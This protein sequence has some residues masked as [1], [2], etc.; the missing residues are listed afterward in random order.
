MKAIINGKIIDNKK[1]HENHALAFDEKI[2][3][4]V[5]M[6]AVQPDWTLIDACGQYVSPGF[7]DTHIHG[8]AGSDVMDASHEAL[9]TISI[10]LLKSGVTSYLPTT[11]TMAKEDIQKALSS[12]QS[13]MNN[14]S[15]T[16]AQI[17]GVHLEGPFISKNYKG[18][19]DASQIIA[20]S[21]GIIDDYLDIIKIITYAPEE[22]QDF[23]FTREM[24]KYDGI[25]LAIGHSDCTYEMALKAFELGVKRITHCFNAMQPLHH[26]NPGII[27]ASL[28]KP[29]ISEFIADGIHSNIEF[30]RSFIKTRHVN[31]CCLI[32]DSMRASFLESGDYDLGGQTVVVDETSARLKDGTLAGSILKMDQAVKNVSKAPISLAEAVYM[33]TQVP[34]HSMGLN[35][36]GSFKP[37]NDADIIF[38]DSNIHITRVFIKSKE[39][40]F[41]DH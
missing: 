38:F 11:M 22:D 20:P 18:A 4:I 40:T 23:A 29:F 10:T 34:A 19:Q 24:Q 12:V 26:R 27:G 1:I 7:I 8:A 2:L 39:V 25:Q 17:L 37:Q 32:T 21:L 14:Q 13:Y 35:H 9:K 31:C 3:G 33:A 28:T 15:K 5:P 6:D 36:I 41:E 16:E 30:L